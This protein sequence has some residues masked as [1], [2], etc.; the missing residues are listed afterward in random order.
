MRDLLV[1]NWQTLLQDQAN[2]HCEHCISVWNPLYVLSCFTANGLFDVENY[3]LS[4]LQK[5]FAV[6]FDPQGEYCVAT[7]DQDSGFIQEKRYCKKERHNG[8]MQSQS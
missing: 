8:W 4:H 1:E 7:S 5:A 6:L 3:M 2:T